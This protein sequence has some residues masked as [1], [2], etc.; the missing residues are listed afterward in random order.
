MSLDLSDLPPL[1]SPSP[2]SNTLLI[3]NLNAPEI[4]TAANL[5]SIRSAVDARAPLHSFSPLKSMRRIIC[6][7]H[8]TDDAVRLREQLDGETVMDARVRVYFGAETRTVA[9][10]DDP[11]RHLRAPHSG[12]LFLI[13]PP[14]SPP[15]GWEMRDE[16]APNKEV[17][18]DDLVSALAKVHARPGP[19]D[20]LMSDVAVSVGGDGGNTA[21][22][23][24]ST[25]TIV[26]DP[27]EQ[28]HSPQL[29]AIAVEDTS[30]T[31]EASSPLETSETKFIHTSRP[32]LE[33]MEC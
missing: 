25:G 6:A 16:E 19:R 33:L 14:P 30:A 31:P 24:S 29:P 3:T 1:I 17:H 10:A 22:T 7:F 15:C 18:A 13:S 27:Q 20:A 2:P 28:G 4:F 5:A 9:P 32:P 12:K 11:G 26:Y 23:R 8:S 21:R